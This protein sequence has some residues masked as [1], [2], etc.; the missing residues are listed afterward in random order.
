MDLLQ[1][2]GV[3]S[4]SPSPFSLLL[5]LGT[6]PSLISL[7][8]QLYQ[9]VELCLGSLAL[10]HTLHCLMPTVL[11]VVVSGVLFSVLLVWLGG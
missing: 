7:N 2:S 11:K 5:S 8:F 4:L 1:T 3:L 9:G 10:S 6:L